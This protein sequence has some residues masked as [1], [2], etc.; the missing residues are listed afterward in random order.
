MT[1]EHWARYLDRNCVQLYGEKKKQNK[2]V[3]L[4]SYHTKKFKKIGHLA[5]VNFKYGLEWDQKNQL[6]SI[7]SKSFSKRC[8]CSVRV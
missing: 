5:H 6:W 3:T 7:K 2:E 4:P 1:L 8:K